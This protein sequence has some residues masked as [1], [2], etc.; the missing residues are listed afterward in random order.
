[1][2]LAVL[3]YYNLFII[4]TDTQNKGYSYFCRSGYWIANCTNCKHIKFTH[5]ITLCYL[6]TGRSA[7]ITI[8]CFRQWLTTI[9]LCAYYIT[10]TI[11]GQK[12]GQFHATSNSVDN[13]SVLHDYPLKG[14]KSHINQYW[15]TVIHKNHSRLLLV[16]LFYCTMK[17][18][19][20]KKTASRKND[21]RQ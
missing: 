18:W 5:I 7:F 9:K 19:I 15:A 6:M 20:L 13:N 11:T 8:A 14:D 21:Q 2:W 4:T 16:L 12:K 3:F 10:A 17:T 1:M